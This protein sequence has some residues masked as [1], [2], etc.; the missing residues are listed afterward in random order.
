MRTLIGGTIVLSVLRVPFLGIAAGAEAE[1]SAVGR[2]AVGR[3]L[4]PPVCRVCGESGG[5]ERGSELV[6]LAIFGALAGVMV[7]DAVTVSGGG[8]SESVSDTDGWRALPLPDSGGVPPS[9]ITDPTSG[10]CGGRGLRRG[11]SAC[12]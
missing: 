6:L 7:S 9:Y 5:L 10:P 1:L 2:L 11:L 8:S 12:I 4:R 3:R